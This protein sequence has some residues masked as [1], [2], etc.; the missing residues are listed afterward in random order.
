MYPTCNGTF[1][2]FQTDISALL[3][4]TEDMIMTE[5]SKK[6]KKKETSLQ[7]SKKKEYLNI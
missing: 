4:N 1:V 5:Q 7:C 2:V 3:L 6:K